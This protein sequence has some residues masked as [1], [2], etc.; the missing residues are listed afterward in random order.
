LLPYDVV[1]DRHGYAWAGGEYSDRIL[2]LDPKTGEFTEYRLPGFVNVRRVFVD[3]S[4]TPV[5][6]WVGANHTASIIKLEPL[7]AAPPITTTSGR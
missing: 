7:D 6:F 1:V 4:T 2:R 3:N 5:A